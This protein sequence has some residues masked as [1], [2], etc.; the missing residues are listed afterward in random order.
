MTITTPSLQPVAWSDL[1]DARFWRSLAPQLRIGGV[2]S[3]A[4]AAPR[5]SYER[6]AQRMSKDAI[7][8]TA[9]R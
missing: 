7:S 8:A 9:T 1:C 4:G 6:L 5:Q 3:D 2:Q